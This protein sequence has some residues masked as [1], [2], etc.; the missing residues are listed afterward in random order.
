MQG[1][2]QLPEG[3]KLTAA[4]LNIIAAGLISAAT[5]PVL[6]AVA[7][8]GFDARARALL[9]LPC[10]ALVLGGLLHLLGR[11]VLRETGS[12]KL[13]LRAEVSRLAMID[14]VK[15]CSDH[16]S[17][18]PS[19]NDIDIVLEE[20]G[21]DARAAIGALLHDLDALI[22]DEAAERSKVR[23][24]WHCQHLRCLGASQSKV[25]ERLRSGKAS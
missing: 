21:N 2:K 14:Q 19:D 8:E 20:F 16:P 7:I 25:N 13:P 10:F 6:Y 15:E 3:R 18:F 11:F 17:S 23:S 12:K 24:V 9:L 22:G 1:T 4:W 5:V